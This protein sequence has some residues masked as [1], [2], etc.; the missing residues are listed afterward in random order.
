VNFTGGFLVASFLRRDPGVQE[1]QAKCAHKTTKVR[2][3]LLE[4]NT[5]GKQQVSCMTANETSGPGPTF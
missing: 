4:V 2:T 5:L 3:G 1:G